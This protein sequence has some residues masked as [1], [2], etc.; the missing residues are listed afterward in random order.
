MM[1]VPEGTNKNEYEYFILIS[2]ILRN[3]KYEI[4]DIR[5]R[6]TDFLKEKRRL[7]VFQ[8][9][10]EPHKTFFKSDKSTFRTDKV[11]YVEWFLYVNYYF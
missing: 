8:N 10:A 5:I 2:L 4:F 7:G 3:L 11:V 1:Q 6:L 9:Y